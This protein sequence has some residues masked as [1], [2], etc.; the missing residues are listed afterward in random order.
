MNFFLLNYNFKEKKKKVHL[1]SKAKRFL[2]M[3]QIKVSKY[4]NTKK[5]TIL[6]RKFGPV[7]SKVR[8]ESFFIISSPQMKDIVSHNEILPYTST[9]KLEEKQSL[10]SENYSTSQLK[11]I[12]C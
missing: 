9:F 12:L 4:Q 11:Y 5:M 6:Q 10:S 7:L 1:K 2:E 8:E 3:F